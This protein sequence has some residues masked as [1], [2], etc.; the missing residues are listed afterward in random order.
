[1]TSSFTKTSWK[2]VLWLFSDGWCMAPKIQKMDLLATTLQTLDITEG[3]AFE[4][5][6]GIKREFPYF[7]IS[8]VPEQHKSAF[9]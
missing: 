6:L 7:H 5:C 2:T 3:L 4:C 1:M 8:L 9:L